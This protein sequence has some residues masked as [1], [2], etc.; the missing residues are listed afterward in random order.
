MPAAVYQLQSSSASPVTLTEAKAHLRIS[1]PAEDALLQSI[2]DACTEWGESYTRRS[3]RAQVWKLL[4]DA[5]SSRIEI[6]RQLVDAITSITHIVSDAPVTV[7][8]DVYY[9]KQTPQG[10]EILLAYGQDWPTDT[11]YRE[12]AITVNFT[13]AAWSRHASLIHEALLKHIAAMYANRGDCVDGG[14]GGSACTAADYAQSSGAAS[15]Y[16]M[17]RVARV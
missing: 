1:S 12:Q 3:F 17:L 16:D 8:S 11:D 5:F 14:S 15:L 10:A 7:A 2:I 6:R 9:L 13:T 4:L